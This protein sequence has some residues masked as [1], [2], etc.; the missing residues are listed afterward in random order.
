MAL[1]GNEGKG[2]KGGCVFAC[3]WT[4][5]GGLMNMCLCVLLHCG[6]GHRDRM[7]HVKGTRRTK[8]PIF[9]FHLYVIDEPG[10]RLLQKT[11]YH[12]QENSGRHVFTSYIKLF[13]RRLTRV[14]SA[15]HSLCHIAKPT[16]QNLT[17][18]SV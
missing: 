5:L 8:R 10:S 1:W 18:C 12:R 9:T 14:W 13:Y 15:H 4:L 2:L 3:E 7:V 16:G 17:L 11:N 6:A